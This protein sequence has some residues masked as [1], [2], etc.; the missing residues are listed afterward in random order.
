MPNTVSIRVVKT[1]IFVSEPFTA[2]SNSTPSERPIQLRCMTL[3]RSGQSTVS[4]SF[5]SCSA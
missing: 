5:S 2:R 3:T 1:R 4:R